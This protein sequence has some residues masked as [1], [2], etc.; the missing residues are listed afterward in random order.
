VTSVE[1]ENGQDYLA[2]LG[3]VHAAGGCHRR[4]EA[5][6]VPGVAHGEAGLGGRSGESLPRV[7]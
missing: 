1:A 6:N 2:A 4:A 7:G 5:W 3:E